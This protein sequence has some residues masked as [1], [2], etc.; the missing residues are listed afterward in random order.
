MI[1]IGSSGSMI[2][3]YYRAQTLLLS[4]YFNAFLFLDQQPNGNES[5]PDR[6]EDMHH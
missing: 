4:F 5:C 2:R 6:M 1:S 3:P